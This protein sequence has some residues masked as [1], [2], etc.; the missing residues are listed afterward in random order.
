MTKLSV[1]TLALSLASAF[2]SQTVATP[3]IQFDSDFNLYAFGVNGQNYKL[4][5]QDGWAQ[6]P[7][8]TPMTATGAP[9]FDGPNTQ[10]YLAQFFNSIYVIDGD[11]ANPGNVHIFNAA[12][13]SWS[14][15]T[16][17]LSTGLDLNTA[18]A[19]LDHDTNVFFALSGKTLYQLDMGQ[20]NSAK[21][22]AIGWEDVQDVGF[23]TDGYKPVMALAQNHIH[24]LN[25]PGS[26]PGQ[27]FIFVIHFAFSQPDPQSYPSKSGPSFPVTHGQSP[28]IFN[29]NTEQV[30]KQF[31]FIPDDGSATY[32]VN[33]EN[34]STVP[35]AGPTVKGPGSVYASSSS[36]LVQF[37]SDGQLFFIPV[38]ATAAPA[39]G[40]QWSKV[41]VAFPAA[42]IS[43]SSAP[44]TPVS[45]VSVPSSSGFVTKQ[46]P[47]AITPSSAPSSSSP[48]SA[49]NGAGSLGV[50]TT[51]M[52]G[53]MTSVVFAIFG[54]F[55]L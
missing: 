9:P 27:A 10:C 5:K 24:F 22:S 45:S 14:T 12:S 42:P 53:L 25:V 7:Q 15:Q 36:A 18:T 29:A 34:N 6:N 1:F 38:D 54:A 19:I 44:P 31:A 26:Q 41:N 55:M 32:I 48:S 37:T 52:Y 3:C 8:G 17:T 51:G 47:P 2:V 50:S 39:V 49:A 4:G 11:K 33:V 21:P 46:S 30:Q 20:Q 28:S 13:Q 40:A 16:T 35:L 23:I 43:S